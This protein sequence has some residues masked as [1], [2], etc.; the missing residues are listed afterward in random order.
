MN[1]Y[2]YVI[3][4]IDS[5]TLL[6]DYGKNH[7]AEIGDKVGVIAIGPEIKDIKG[8]V[9]GTFDGIKAELNI[10]KIYDSFS[11]CKSIKVN[12]QN[13]M[14]C[15]SDSNNEYYELQVVHSEITTLNLSYEKTIRLGDL[16]EIVL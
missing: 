15:F 2:Y 12:E 11:V 4:I 8:N 7:G 16:V 9:I 10:I 6:I 1:R 13:E 14:L 3:K 5:K